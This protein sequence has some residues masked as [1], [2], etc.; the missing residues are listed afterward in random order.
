MSV[1]LM[2]GVEI[3][4]LEDGKRKTDKIRERFCKKV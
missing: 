2:H 4:D 1:R 3:S